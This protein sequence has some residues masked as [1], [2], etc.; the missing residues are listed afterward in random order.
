[1][2]CATIC[3][4]YAKTLVQNFASQH[5]QRDLSPCLLGRGLEEEGVALLGAIQGRSAGPLWER[6]LDMA[7]T[8]D[9]GAT[10]P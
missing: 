2:S 4:H 10:Y 1:M 5:C 8:S 3:A 7:G 6:L 9:F